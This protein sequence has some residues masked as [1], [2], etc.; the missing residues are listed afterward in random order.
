MHVHR[1]KHRL[2][3]IAAAAIL[4]AAVICAPQS[5]HAQNAPASTAQVTA[6]AWQEQEQNRFATWFEKHPA[7]VLIVP[8][9]VSGYAL[10]P[11]E[12]SLMTSR[13]ADA[14]ASK[15]TLTLA[16]PMLADRALGEGLRK[17]D[18]TEVFALANRIHARYVILGTTG[19]D[20][21]STWRLNIRAVQ[22]DPTNG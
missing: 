18:E 15:T 12:R 2:G 14:L 8:F 20:G 6:S 17:Y 3:A 10:D 1:G 7:D 9:Q 4:Q 5:L 21:Q 16:D 19:H 22:K 13:L 11:A